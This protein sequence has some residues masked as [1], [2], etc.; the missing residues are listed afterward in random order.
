MMLGLQELHDLK[1]GQIGRRASPS[2][3]DILQTSESAP[4][5]TGPVTSGNNYQASRSY[6]CMWYTA[7][8][9]TVTLWQ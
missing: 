4:A 9:K 8:G 2:W 5:G 6:L 3:G 7:A 1:S